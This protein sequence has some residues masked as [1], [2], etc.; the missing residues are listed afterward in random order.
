[1]RLHRHLTAKTSQS[2]S[3]HTVLMGEP[4]PLHSFEGPAAM[5]LHGTA[6][7]L[8]LLLRQVLLAG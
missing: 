7:C 1:M 5:R 6:Y 2:P 3:A 8:L 4:P